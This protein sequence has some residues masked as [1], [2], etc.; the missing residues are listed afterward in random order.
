MRAR[1][2]VFAG[3]KEM[4]MA[5]IHNG[6]LVLVGDGEKAIFLRNTGGANRAMKLT[7][8]RVLEQNNPPTRDQGADRP[9]RKPGGDGLSRSA[10]EETDWHQL[11]EDRFAGEISKALFRLAHDQKF[12]QLI[13]VAPPKVLGTLRE[14]LHK[15]VTD[16]I[17]IEVPKELTAHSVPDIE[18]VLKAVA[19]EED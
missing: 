18:K 13:V 4:S 14:S 9:G 2:L 8:E 12:A 19:E 10:I 5:I 1:V 16:R 11:A 3:F 6:A 15:E 17:T 7:V